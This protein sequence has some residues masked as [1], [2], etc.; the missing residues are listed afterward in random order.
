MAKRTSEADGIQEGNESAPMKRQCSAETTSTE[1]SATSPEARAKA[2]SSSFASLSVRELKERIT[3]YGGDLTGMTE[4][5]E[6]VA[7]LEMLDAL[8]IPSPDGPPYL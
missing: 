8:Q 1:A 2:Q 6:L 4:K 5:C 3:A 7:Y